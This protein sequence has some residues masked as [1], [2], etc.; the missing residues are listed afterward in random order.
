ML[1]KILTI[2]GPTASGK[3]KVSLEI[4]DKINGEIISADSRQVY[5]YMDI[6][7]AK[8]TPEERSRIPHH[9]LDVVDPDE[10]FSA[11]DYSNKSLRAIKEVLSRGKEPIVVGGSGLYLRALFKGFFKGPGRDEKLRQQLKEKADKFGAELLYRE[12]KEKDPEAAEKI[13][14]HNLARIIRALEVFELTGEKISYLQKKGEY[15]SKEFEFIKI[16][17]ELDR[18]KLYQRIDQRVEYMI[19]SGL[20]DEVKSL[21]IKGYD[22]LLVPMRTFGYQEILQYLEAKISLE[23]AK[24]KIKQNTRHYAKRQLTWFKKEENI[25]WLNAEKKY[26]SECILKIFGN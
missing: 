3:T 23:E 4:A 26:L 6:G 19:C 12:L 22:N 11:A 10:Y 24:S 18:E 21:K 1:K 2:L 17:L 13:G 8:P 16:G 25:S 7:T 14:P 20:I 5:R 9:L 15:P